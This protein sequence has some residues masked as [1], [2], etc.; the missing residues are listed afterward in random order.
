M[1]LLLFLLLAALGPSVF[2]PDLEW[3]KNVEWNAPDNGHSIPMG[4]AAEKIRCLG[5]R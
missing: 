4:D 2:E 3:R 1:L 5:H